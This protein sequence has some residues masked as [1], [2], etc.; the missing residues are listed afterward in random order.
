MP[1]LSNVDRL[2]ALRGFFVAKMPSTTATRVNRRLNLRVFSSLAG[3][4]ASELRFLNWSCL[5]VS[6]EE[7]TIESDADFIRATANAYVHRGLDQN[8]KEPI[9][10]DESS[11]SVPFYL[12]RTS[13]GLWETALRH[14]IAID[15]NQL[16]S[17][18]LFDY[19]ERQTAIAQALEQRYLLYKEFLA[20]GDFESLREAIAA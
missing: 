16:V 6:V 2:A 9:A 1:S 20:A 19:F 10:L 3:Q 4:L 14:G 13:Q 15:Y 18:A 8:F 17:S 11:T 7:R 12:D 5:S